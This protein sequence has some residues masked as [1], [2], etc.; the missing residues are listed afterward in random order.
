M[1]YLIK[2]FSCSGRIIG[3]WVNEGV[4]NYLIVNCYLPCDYRNEESIL[5]YRET[6]AKLAN[7]LENENFK[8]ICFVGDFNADPASRFYC[9]LLNFKDSYNLKIVDIDV[10]PCDSFT[11]N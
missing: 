6:I 3:I 5:E 8:E 11:Y 4:S 10:L 9:E 2:L 1:R 7:V